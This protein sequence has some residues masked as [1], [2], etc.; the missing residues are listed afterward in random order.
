M[1]TRQI[2]A[3]PLLA[4]ALALLALSVAASPARAFLPIIPNTCDP[5]LLYADSERVIVDTPMGQ[6]TLQLFPSVAPETVANFLGYIQR[7]DYA[8]TI[9]HRVV[10]DFVV[11][12][13]GFKS[14]GAF[15]DRITVGPQI[16]NEPC[17][18]NVAGTIAMARLGGQVNSATSQ[19][20]VN[21][22]DNG[23]G[24]PNLDEADE[25]FTVFGRVLGD[26]IDVAR[27]I[28]AV[29]LT[30][31][32]TV[33]PM[34]P[35][36]P[37]VLPELPIFYATTPQ[38]VWQFFRA[39]P[40]QALPL[41]DP[42]SYGC[43]D[44]GQA[45]ILLSENPTSVTDWEPNPTHGLPYY[46]VS[47]GCQ[48]AGTGGVPAV[49]CSGPGR[50]ALLIDEQTGAF[51]PDL[52]AEF[53]VAEVV[54]DCDDIAASETGLDLRLSDVGTQLNQDFVMPTYTVPEPHFGLSAAASL[55]V[56]AALRR[57]RSTA[58]STVER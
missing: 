12:T 55:L 38:S 49:S 30:L 18:S 39:A 7:G 14:S 42:P 25:G 15:F 47:D 36:S 19:W 40:I 45:A 6:M 17:I 29:D 22:E 2:R 4:M 8:D 32:E 34:D 27:A 24:M 21:L 48:G 3:N 50:R 9:F 46:L 28:A 31:A 26:G 13:G 41:V 57:R 33:D 43:F 56:L 11:Q 44:S 54:L 53:N 10:P 58:P 1:K 16:D 20:F 37:L 23:G 5:D 51:L 52:N 35:T